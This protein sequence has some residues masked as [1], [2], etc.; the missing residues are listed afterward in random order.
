[1]PNS[2]VIRLGLDLETCRLNESL[3]MFGIQVLAN[4]IDVWYLYVHEWVI[5]MFLLQGIIPVPWILWEIEH[6]LWES[7]GTPPP[8]MVVPLLIPS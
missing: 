4:P 2:H 3:M 5:F 6:I 1:M 8:Q 7:K